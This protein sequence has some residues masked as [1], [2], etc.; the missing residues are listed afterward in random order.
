MG[1]RITSLL[2]M[3][4]QIPEDVISRPPCIDKDQWRS[5]PCSGRNYM[6]TATGCCWPIVRIARHCAIR[7]VATTRNEPR[8]GEP[9][10]LFRR[11]ASR[12]GTIVH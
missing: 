10:A 5:L 2:F 6:T 12:H 3:L 9:L 1:A 7:G 4:E 11:T 8:R